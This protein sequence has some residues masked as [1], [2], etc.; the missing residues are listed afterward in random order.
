MQIAT[1]LH[2]FDMGFCIQIDKESDGWD[3]YT[4]QFEIGAPVGFACKVRDAWK[5]DGIHS[6]YRLDDDEVF[7]KDHTINWVGKI[8]ETTKHCTTSSK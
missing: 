6:V 5:T 1:V 2:A 7:E 4:N 8:D 3:C